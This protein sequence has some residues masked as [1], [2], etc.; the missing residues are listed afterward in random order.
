MVSEDRIIARIER[1]GRFRY[2]AWAQAYEGAL[3]DCV[4][5]RSPK[6]AQRKLRREVKRTLRY[7]QWKRAIAQVDVTP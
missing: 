2:V 1:V 5:A 4:L 7:R 3:S 6:A